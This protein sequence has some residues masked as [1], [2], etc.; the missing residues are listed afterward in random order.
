MSLDK[1]LG[2]SKALEIL[3][4]L[5]EEPKH[6]RGL[7]RSLGGSL[8]TIELRVNSLIQ[9]DLIREIEVS[10]P[11]R[12]LELT[13]RGENLVTVLRT[14]DRPSTSPQVKPILEGKERWILILLYALGHIKGNMRLEKLLFL[15]KEQFKV[16]EEEFYIFRPYLFG[17]FSPEVSQDARILYN[18]KLID[19]EEKV[20]GTLELSDWLFLRKTYKLIEKGRKK[21][22][23]FYKDAAEKPKV[24][25]ALWRLQ[26]YNALPLN[27]LL[28][29]VFKTYPEYS[30]EENNV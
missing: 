27:N 5:Q 28:S 29:Y 9:A 4:A 22:K 2:E 17:P 15:L 14:M 8:S 6:I 1:V 10:S 25:E 23:S 21:A 7:Q 19:I 24:K 20:F 3:F 18:V 30:R 12:S 11:S 13:A 16:V 26:D